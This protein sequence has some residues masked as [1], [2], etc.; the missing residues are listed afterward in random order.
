[1]LKERLSPNKF[2]R[3]S[4]RKGVAMT[5]TIAGICATLIALLSMPAAYAKR[6]VAPVA[7]PE[8][9]FEVIKVK[10]KGGWTE[11]AVAIQNTGSSDATIS[12]CNFFLEND[13]G[14]SVQTL[15]RDE[16]LALIHNKAAAA[17]AIGAL[18]GVGLGVGGA[19]GD[20][21]ELEYAGIA[22]G[23]ASVIA[24]VAG[25]AAEGASRRR[26]VVDNVMRVQK[27]PPGLKVA[28]IVYFPPRKRWPGSHTAAAI[29][30]V[31]E[32]GGTMQRATAPIP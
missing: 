29:H 31:Y 27:F 4:C 22:T 11:A 13:D 32:A 24:G 3:A 28:G 26:V 10:Y 21:E 14:Y 6:P 25:E 12:C 20:I 2:P 15:T 1:M 5:A 19:V 16:V 9:S 23:G 18:V 7:A 17:S 30:L 8:F